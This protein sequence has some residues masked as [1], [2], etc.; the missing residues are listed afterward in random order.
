[1][2]GNDFYTGDEA[3]KILKL[4]PGR[5]SQMLRSGELIGVSPEHSGGRGWKIPMRVMRVMRVVHDRDH[6]ARVER[7]LGP[8]ATHYRCLPF[9][10]HHHP[11][12]TSARLPSKGFRPRP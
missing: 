2:D 3:A 5:I 10:S 6:P 4:T 1:M 7:P 11:R 12:V 8:P 9:R